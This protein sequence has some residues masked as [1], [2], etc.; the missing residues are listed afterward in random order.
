M[1]HFQETNH[2]FSLDVSTRRVWDYISD[3]YVHRIAQNKK[4]GSLVQL[5]SRDDAEDEDEVS[6]QHS[7]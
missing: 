5:D 2:T 1:Q 7:N 3:Q 4:D 6:N